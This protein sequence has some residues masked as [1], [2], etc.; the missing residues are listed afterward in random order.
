MCIFHCIFTGNEFYCSIQDSYI[1]VCWGWGWPWSKS[2]SSSLFPVASLNI[3]GPGDWSFP[4]LLK[5]PSKLE[6]ISNITITV[7]IWWNKI[8]IH[9]N[10]VSWLT[11][12]SASGFSL[13]EKSESWQHAREIG[14]YIITRI[15][16]RGC[17]IVCD[18]YICIQTMNL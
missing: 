1:C 9:T 8:S 6:T 13:L 3:S 15:Y 18:K 14:I 12:F 4:S 11:T 7:K 2:L 17:V 5:A 16:S 10:P